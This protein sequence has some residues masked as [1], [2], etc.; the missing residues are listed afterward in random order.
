MQ[1]MRAIQMDIDL[2]NDRVHKPQLWSDLGAIQLQ[3]FI[4]KADCKTY[5]LVK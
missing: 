4:S 2:D 3:L 1:G 5:I